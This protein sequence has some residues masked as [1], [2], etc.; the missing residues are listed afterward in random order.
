MSIT[1]I[2]HALQHSFGARSQCNE[3][4]IVMVG[5]G[6]DTDVQLIWST[7]HCLSQM[8]EEECIENVILKGYR[9]ENTESWEP[10]PNE[11]EPQPSFQLFFWSHRHLDADTTTFVEDV[12]LNYE[13][14]CTL[15]F[16]P[17]NC[18]CNDPLNCL[19]KVD[20]WHHPG[21]KIVSLPLYYVGTSHKAGHINF[22]MKHEY[23]ER[24][25]YALDGDYEECYVRVT[26]SMVNVK[27]EQA[28]A[29]KPPCE[30][31]WVPRD[32]SVLAFRIIAARR[33]WRR[34]CRCRDNPAFMLCRKRLLREWSELQ[35]I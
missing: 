6:D 33:I 20:K 15:A 4:Y 18:E 32:L 21:W 10:L 25:V 3:D 13:T 26:L 9:C 23:C 8:D 12:C 19:C 31:D 14:L 2:F 24:A 11:N 16:S 35:K 7:E 22:K 1:A 34:W 17:I 29:N 30:F 5:E 27:L 28:V